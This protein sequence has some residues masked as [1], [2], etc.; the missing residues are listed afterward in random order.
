MAHAAGCCSGMGGSVLQKRPLGSTG[1][2]VSVLALGTVK[3]GRNQGVKY[4]Q[5]F[6]LPDDAALTRLL[7]TAS[8][9]GINL[10][11][12]APAYGVSEERLGKLLRGKRQ[13]WVIATK[14]GEEF[15]DGTSHFDFSPA[16]INQSVERSLQRLNTDF[17]DIVMIHSSGNDEQL[18]L[19]DGVFDTLSRLKDQGKLRAFGMSTKTTA[20]G[21]M[22]VDQ[23]DLV[24]MTYH[25]KYIEEQSVITHAHQNRKG[26][27]IK[28]AFASG[29][30]ELLPGEDPVV[31]SLRFILKEPGV[32]TVVVGTI[33]DTHMRANADAVKKVTG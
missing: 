13:D 26:I 24:M 3:F 4:P 2:L 16:A 8:D 31:E 27:L 9:L 32:T 33:N 12:T 23:A 22:T 30:L 6:A 15:I 11:D 18:I 28:K 14:A 19:E 5:A 25:P 1:I 29:H 7:E 20:G 10:L 17:L 21:L